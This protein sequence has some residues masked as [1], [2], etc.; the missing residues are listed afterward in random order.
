MEDNFN[1]KPLKL[2]NKKLKFPISFDLKVVMLSDD[3]EINKDIIIASLNDLKIP[4][5][6]WQVKESSNRTYKRYIDKVTL[7][8]HSKMLKM[9]HTLSKID[10]VKV[11]L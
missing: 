10:K 2:N 3:D 11:V 1:Y 8:N 7:I 5:N 4:H 9:Y 6:G